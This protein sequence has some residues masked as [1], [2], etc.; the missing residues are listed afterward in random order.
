M[1]LIEKFEQ[2]AFAFDQ[3]VENNEGESRTL[4]AVRDALLPKLISGEI[5]VKDGEEITGEAH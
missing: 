2:I 3:G 4:A 1:G 5:R